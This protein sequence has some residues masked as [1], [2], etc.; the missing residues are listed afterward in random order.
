MWGNINSLSVPAQGCTDLCNASHVAL[1]S[2]TLY[3][4]CM[5]RIPSITCLLE[6]SHCP[7]VCSWT[8]EGPNRPLGT[9]VRKVIISCAE[10]CL[11][12]S[13]SIPRN[14]FLYACFQA[15]AIQHLQ[16]Q[17]QAGLLLSHWSFTIGQFPVHGSSGDDAEISFPVSSGVKLNKLN[18]RECA[19]THKNTAK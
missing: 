17:M 3:P 19:F 1:Q 8:K 10:C 9:L 6:H 16:L 7:W 5:L 13:P 12:D 11:G 14:H 2:L 15:L 4:G 18:S